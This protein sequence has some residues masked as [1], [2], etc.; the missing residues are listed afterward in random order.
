MT[1]NNLRRLLVRW[2][3]I[4]YLNK[5]AERVYNTIRGQSRMQGLIKQV[6]NALLKDLDLGAIKE[7]AAEII[8]ARAKK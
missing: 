4:L 1:E 7:Q 8:A 6:A 2:L 3:K 5:F